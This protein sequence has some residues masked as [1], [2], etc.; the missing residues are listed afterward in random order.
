MLGSHTIHHW[1]ST[2]SVVALSSAEAELNAIVK[3]ISEVLCVLHMAE[4]CGTKLQGEVCTDSSAANGIVHR[5]G[6]GKVKHLEC[7]QLWVQEVVSSG[8]V[9]V[10]KIPRDANPGDA[11]THYWS[12]ADGEKHFAKMN[13]ENSVGYP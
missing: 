2:Q 7:R 5:Q 11:L 13:V 10:K 6:C 4:E 9:A 12:A 1:S 3:S 8:T